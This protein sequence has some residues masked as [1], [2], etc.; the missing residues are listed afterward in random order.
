MEATSKAHKIGDKAY[1]STDMTVKP[2]LTPKDKKKLKA[3]VM[4]A[5]DAHIGSGLYA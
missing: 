3:S 1:I 2:G 5:I 4:K